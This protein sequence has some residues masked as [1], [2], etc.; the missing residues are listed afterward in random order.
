M[1]YYGLFIDGKWCDASRTMAVTNP[2]TGEVIAEVAEAGSG[3]TR[4]A[5]DAAARAFPN[6]AALP[7]RERAGLMRQVADRIRM[8][9]DLL[10]EILTAEQ[11]KPLREAKA[12]VL[13]SADYFEWNGEEAKRIYGET[14]PASTP[15]KR[16][17]AIRQPVGVVAAITPW[18]FPASMIAR[19]VSPALAAGCTVVIKPAESTPLSAL[20]MGKIFEEV[21]MPPGVVNIV[22]GPPE[23]IADELLNHPVVRKISFTGSTVVGQTLM[24][25]A[26]QGL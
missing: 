7:A 18:N 11:G 15:N 1:K 10:A 26:A 5:I 3:E 24:K 17:L 9:A 23:P 14:I 16:L 19:K 2:A 6:W 8:Q 20:A 21:G 25:R 13:M 4:N 22:V 12:E